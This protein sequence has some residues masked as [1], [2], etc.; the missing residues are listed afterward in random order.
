MYLLLIAYAGGLRILAKF[1]A[2]ANDL[3]ARANRWPRL[4]L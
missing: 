1:G 2:A 4:G 3:H